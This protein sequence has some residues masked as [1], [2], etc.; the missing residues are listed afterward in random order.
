VSNF[1]D[2]DNE[3]SFDYM[4]WKDRIENDI[5]HGLQAAE[6]VITEVSQHAEELPGLIH[7]AQDAPDNLRALKIIGVV[8]AVLLVINLVRS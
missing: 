6:S 7:N 2:T 5:E 1:A 3:D 4:G 8:I